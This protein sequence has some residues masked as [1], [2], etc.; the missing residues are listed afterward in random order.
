MISPRMSAFSPET[1]PIT[2]SARMPACWK[3]PLPLGRMPSPMRTRL[4]RPGSEVMA[5]PPTAA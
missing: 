4:M 3:L 5:V 2:L 1:E